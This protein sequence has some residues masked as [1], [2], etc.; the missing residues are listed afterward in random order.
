[1]AWGP[2]NVRKWSSLALLAI[3]GTALTAATDPGFVARISQKGLDFVCQESM[4]ELQK[5]LLAIS[6]PDFSGDFKIKHLGKGTYEFYS[7]AVEGF[8][9]PD[10]Q[11]KLLPSD[12]LQLSI[13]SA[14]IKISGR[15]KY[16]KNILKAS[17]NF[18]LSI[19]G[20]SIIADLI[21]GN[22]PSGRI[23]ITCST[24]DS[25]INSV[26]IKVSGSMLGWL[27]QLFHR[28]IETSLKKTIYKKICKIVRNSVSAK[29][30]PYVK[31]LPVVAKVD[32][33]TSI[34]YSLL[35]PPMTTDK[36]L[37]G[38]LRGEFFWRGHHGPL[39]AVPPVMNILPNNSY[40]VCMGISDYFFNTAEFAYQESKTLKITLRDQLLAKDARYH[41]N[42]D[43]LRTF[44]PEVAKK[45][46]SMGVQLLISAP[47]FAHLNIQPSGLSLSP[48]L[49][50][51]AFVVHPNSSLI[52][53]F[54]LGM[55]TNASLEVNAMKNRLIGEMKLGRLLLELKQSNFGSF[56]VELLED[57][58]NYLM[59]TMVLP[60]INEKLRRGFPL[61]L[62][63]GIQ[64][65][66]SILYSSQN[67][68]LLEADL[69]RT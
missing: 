24:C 30:Q 11:I 63:A 26:R 45:F 12:G 68:L 37:E 69:R 36:F 62:P 25:H 41:L 40:M 43:F 51:R 3:V 21:L 15:W 50:T 14:R 53:L 32:D 49:E 20:V 17:G 13:T 47:S 28:K 4:V 56:K 33:I 64:L 52:P 10:P 60:K 8:H 38:Q 27:I 39:P 22:D 67:F 2:D 1:M 5:E 19:Q 9:I 34:D 55:K 29:L 35:A 58:I 57:V 6:I 16:R 42:T 23:T 66:N 61:P 65:I 44:L 48:N 18:Q 7:M 54:L 31:T 59:S 46:P